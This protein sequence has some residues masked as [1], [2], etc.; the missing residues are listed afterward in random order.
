MML[1]P[2]KHSA[3]TQAP[4]RAYLVL[5][6]PVDRCWW[7]RSCELWPHDYLPEENSFL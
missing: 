1:I 7:A 3:G 2:I 5:D 4:D 6:R